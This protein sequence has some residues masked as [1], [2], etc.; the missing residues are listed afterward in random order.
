MPT[1]QQLVRKGRAKIR[2]KSKAPAPIRPLKAAGGVADIPINS[3][4]EFH[5]SDWLRNHGWPCGFKPELNLYRSRSLG[6]V[7]RWAT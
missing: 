4:G 7:L 2:V 6:D 1:I 3:S 5:D